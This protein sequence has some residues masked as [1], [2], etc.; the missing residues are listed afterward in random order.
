MHV[1]GH[2]R[3]AIRTG[4]SQCAIKV[5]KKH[6]GKQQVQIRDADRS[7]ADAQAISVQKHTG[8]ITISATLVGLCLDRWRRQRAVSD[9]R[10]RMKS[11]L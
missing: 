3:T 2:Y 4:L 11:D 8:V 9:D 1:Y 10:Q 7:F 6:F 5:G